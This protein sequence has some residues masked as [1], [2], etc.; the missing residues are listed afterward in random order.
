MSKEPLFL[1]SSS[2]ESGPSSR[3]PEKTKHVKGK[4]VMAYV[5]VPKADYPIRHHQRLEEKG[6]ASEIEVTRDRL[7]RLRTQSSS[8]STSVVGE[9]GV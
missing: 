4:E 2:P 8:V 3:P 5:L 7:K 6:E 1:P 9:E